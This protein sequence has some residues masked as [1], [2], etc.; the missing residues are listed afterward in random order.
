[1]LGHGG[2]LVLVLTFVV[3]VASSRG[4]CHPAVLVH[5]RL[6]VAGQFFVQEVGSHAADFNVGV[7]S[8][9]I[10]QAHPEHIFIY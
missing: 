2:F 4:S 3:D 5:G 1:M 9:P 7:I 6:P 8:A 10:L